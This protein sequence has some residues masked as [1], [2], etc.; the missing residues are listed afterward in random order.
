MNHPD[1]WQGGILNRRDAFW[2]AT[3]GGCDFSADGHKMT[4]LLKPEHD[5]P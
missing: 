4:L 1:G 3:S 5:K 2:R